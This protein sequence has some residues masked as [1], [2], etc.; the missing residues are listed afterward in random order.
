M[1]ELLKMVHKVSDQAE[2]YAIEEKKSKVTFENGKL[3]NIESSIQSGM[4]LRVIKGKKLG[5]VYTKNLIDREA[6]IRSATESFKAGAEGQ[7]EFPSTGNVH[8]L[9]TYDPSIE[10]LTN[11]RI[12]EE[13]RRLFDRLKGRSR[14]QINIEAGSVTKRIRILNSRGTDLS[15]NISEYRI[16]PFT[17]Y[18]GSFS[19]L[20]RVFLGKS[21]EE[22]PEE[23]LDHILNL[24]SASEKEVKIKAKKMK[25]LFLPETMYVLIWRLKSATSGRSLYHHESPLSEKIGEKI[26]HEKLTIFDD[27][28]NDR[29][30]GARAFDDEGIPCRFLPLVKKGVLKNVYYDLCYAKKLKAEPT[31]HGYKTDMWETET[32][33]IRPRPALRHVVIETG[34]LTLSKMIE[35]IDHGIIVGQALGAHSGNIANGD[36]SIGLSPGLCVENGEIVGHVKDTMVSGNVYETLRNVISIESTT[37]HAPCGRFPALLVDDV[38]VSTKKV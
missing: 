13:C 6:F 24:F 8:S 17:L 37:H 14:G 26:F 18:P 28:L 22:T 1:E 23:I 34:D 25:V 27:P 29:S 20:S 2:V 10:S 36:Y 21:F 3:K 31:G 35:S 19:A 7:I 30:P 9:N 33:S 4:S 32:I 5:F 38:M 15:S 11:M 16:I 12:V